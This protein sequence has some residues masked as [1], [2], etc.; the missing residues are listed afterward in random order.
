MREGVR[1]AYLVLVLLA[2]GA[3]PVVAQ[4][5]GRGGEGLPPGARAERRFEAGMARVVQRRLQLSAGQMRQLR[6]SNRQFARQRQELFQRERTVRRALRRE[7]A[8]G[9][10]AAQARVATLLDQL[11]DVQR[12]RLAL[13]AAEQRDLA[14]FMTPVQRAKYLELQEQLRRRVEGAVQGGGREGRRPGAP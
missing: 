1:R 4:A 8:A 3:L 11:I 9:D 14:G 12:Q 7:L 2:A 13:V 6:E 5:P 10:G